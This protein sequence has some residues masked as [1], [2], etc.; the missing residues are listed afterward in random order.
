MSIFSNEV[1]QRLDQSPPA[2]QEEL[3]HLVSQVAKLV[4]LGPFLVSR[5]VWIHEFVNS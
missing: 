1:A 3:T 5:Q 4:I 2:C